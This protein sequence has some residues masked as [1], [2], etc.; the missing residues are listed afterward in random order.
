VGIVRNPHSTPNFTYGFNFNVKYK[1]FSLSGLIQGTGPRDMYMNGTLMAQDGPGRV[2]YQFQMDYWSPTNANSIFPRVGDSGMNGGSNYLPSTFW[3][4]NA[5]YVRLKSLTLSYDIKHALLKKVNNINDL[6]I[7]FSGENLFAISPCL[8][9]GD[10]E[11]SSYD[12][13]PI[14]RVFSCGIRLGI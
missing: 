7:F 3:L 6:S 2:R 8:Q 9:F 5:Q 12:T 10:P 4:I 1:D 13:Y 14:M 11:T